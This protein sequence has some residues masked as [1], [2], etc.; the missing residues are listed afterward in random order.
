V[1]A[2]AGPPQPPVPASPA[3]RHDLRQRI[4]GTICFAVHYRSSKI[5]LEDVPLLRCADSRIFVEDLDKGGN[6]FR[7]GVRPGDELVRIKVGSEPPQ[8]PEGSVETVVRLAQDTRN[9]GQPAIVFFMGFAG[10][11]P[12]EVRV[13]SPDDEHTMALTMKEISGGKVFELHD[14]VDFGQSGASLLIACKPLPEMGLHSQGSSPSGW[15]G[16]APIAARGARGPQGHQ[17]VTTNKGD[18]DDTLDPEESPAALSDGH[19]GAGIACTARGVHEAVVA[20]GQGPACNECSGAFV[21]EQAGD[22][23]PKA[24]TPRAA[25]PW[26]ILELER[27]EA[28]NLL[29]EAVYDM[30][31]VDLGIFC[32]VLDAQDPR[33][34]LGPCGLPR[35]TWQFTV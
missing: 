1:A 20:G 32:K 8:S 11:F 29:A 23:D 2:L 13:S 30:P 3:E 4:T 15:G 33:H 31:S 22:G 14:H 25:V 26:H 28:K 5:I 34:S 35:G 7:A 9:V 12:A 18:P 19:A 27:K 21:E 24:A 16:D 6:A 10:K 17:R